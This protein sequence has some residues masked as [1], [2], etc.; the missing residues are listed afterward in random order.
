MGEVVSTSSYFCGM[1]P[2]GSRS[3]S[4]VVGSPEYRP[5][6]DLEVP[7]PQR[8]TQA[9]RQQI[10]WRERPSGR[11]MRSTGLRDRHGSWHPIS[12]A[13]RQP[14]RI[15]KVLAIVNE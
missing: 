4:W 3:E 2:G 8:G 10:E 12:L 13:R 9:A 14:E 11:S 7:Q 5:P 1:M 15:P 6:L